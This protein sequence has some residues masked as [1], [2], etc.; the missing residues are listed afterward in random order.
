MY[1]PQCNQP[2]WSS[3]NL[4]KLIDHLKEQDDEMEAKN[5][6]RKAKRDAAGYYER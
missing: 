1:S 3:I 2:G 6:E 4:S 5:K